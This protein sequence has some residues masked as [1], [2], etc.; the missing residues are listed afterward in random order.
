MS[1]AHQY[2]D[3]IGLVKSSYVVLVFYKKALR[4]ISLECR[5]TYSYA[6]FCRY[7]IGKLHDMGG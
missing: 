7:E 3:F 1:N 4:I 5:N 2:N 6:L